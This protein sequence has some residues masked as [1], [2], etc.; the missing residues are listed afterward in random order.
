MTETYLQIVPPYG[1][2]VVTPDIPHRGTIEL[3]ELHQIISAMMD[4]ESRHDTL[5]GDDVLSTIQVLATALKDLALQV[6]HIGFGVA[7]GRISVAPVTLA[8]TD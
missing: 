4:I 7:Y 3:D 5:T 1:S 2:A 6:Q 8:E